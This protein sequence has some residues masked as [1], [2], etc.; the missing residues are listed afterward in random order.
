MSF[1]EKRYPLF[2]DMRWDL[3]AYT[4]ARD[5]ANRLSLRRKITHPG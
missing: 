5:A 4:V 2:R 1:S 3:P